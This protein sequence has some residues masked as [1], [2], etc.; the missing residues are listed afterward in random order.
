M[1]TMGWQDGQGLGKEGTGITEAIQVKQKEDT[2]GVR[3]PPPPLNARCFLL[4][5]AMHPVHTTHVCTAANALQ[6]L[7]VQVGGKGG[8][9]WGD[10]WWEKAFDSAVMTVDESSSSDSS[11]SDSGALFLMA[12]HT[13][14]SHRWLITCVWQLPDCHSLMLLLHHS[15]STLPSHRPSLCLAR[16]HLPCTC[17]R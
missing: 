10:K 1:R 5:S 6:I 9:A 11:D 13:R 3:R 17:R 8:Y 15:P 14:A 2:V 7:S 12:A 4:L 16:L